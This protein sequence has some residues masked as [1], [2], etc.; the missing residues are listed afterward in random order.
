MRINAEAPGKIAAWA[1]VRSISVF[2][3]S[4]EDYVF[5]VGLRPVADEF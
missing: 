5:A 1:A 4:T 2:H 3:L